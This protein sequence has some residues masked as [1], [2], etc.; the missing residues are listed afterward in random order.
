MSTPEYPIRNL[1]SAARAAV[2]HVA[3]GHAPGR[4]V[5]LDAQGRKLVDIVVLPPVDQP[6]PI[7]GTVPCLP[8]EIPVE[9][10]PPPG[11]D[12]SGGRAAFEGV[13]VAVKGRPL[14]VLRALVAADGPVSPDQLRRQCWENYRCEESTV[15]WAVGELR[16]ALR[17][18]FPDHEEPITADG[19]G[20][21]YMLNLR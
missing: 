12:F 15:R 9:P 1:Q 17:A 13:P 16:K 4:V 19:T 3:P 8:P 6:T 2:N 10:L 20:A 11:W 7:P 18:A 21:G 5:I 14:A